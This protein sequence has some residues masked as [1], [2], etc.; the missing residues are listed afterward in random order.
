V[1]LV[2]CILR[3]MGKV[4]VRSEFRVFIRGEGGCF[5]IPSSDFQDSRD[6]C[7]PILMLDEVLYSPHLLSRLS[8]EK[9]SRESFI[10]RIRRSGSVVAVAR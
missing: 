4:S 10:L 9:R 3:E 8:L 2:D 1:D 5:W 7:T 6:R